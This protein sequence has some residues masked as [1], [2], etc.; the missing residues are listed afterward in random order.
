MMR[1]DSM[2]SLVLSVAS[3]VLCI[4]CASSALLL[5]VLFL[6]GVNWRGEERDHVSCLVGST[7]DA[8]SRNHQLPVRV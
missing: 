3:A 8:V 5:I 2:R 6:D 7:T 4:E 1:C